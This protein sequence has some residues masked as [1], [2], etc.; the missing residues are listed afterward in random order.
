M[1][2]KVRRL[3]RSVNAFR[4]LLSD[5]RNYRLVAPL[6]MF[7]LCRHSSAILPAAEPPEPAGVGAAPPRLKRSAAKR[8]QSAKGV[9][10]RGRLSE[11]CLQ[12]EE[13]SPSIFDG[14]TPSKMKL[15]YYPQTKSPSFNRT[16]IFVFPISYNFVS[17][18]KL[19]ISFFWPAVSNSMV[20]SVSLP[21]RFASSTEPSPKML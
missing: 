18:A 12:N 4:F 21:I 6:P 20:I 17:F 10:V 9:W 16:V 19:A 13:F 1:L 15:L 8:Q 2:K 11:A 14:S 5:K 3:P 7:S